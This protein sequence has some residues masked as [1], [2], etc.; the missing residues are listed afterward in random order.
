[1]TVRAKGSFAGNFGKDW[2]G[3][4]Q[5]LRQSNRYAEVPARP[6]QSENVNQ[7]KDL[8]GGEGGIRTLGTLRFA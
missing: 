2:D 8:T 5:N 7:I 1:M 3:I 4:A 6:R